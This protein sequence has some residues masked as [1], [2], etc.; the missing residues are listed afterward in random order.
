MSVQG[1]SN[2][3]ASDWKDLQIK[4]IGLPAPLELL[5]G[6]GQDLLYRQRT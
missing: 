6:F 5:V 1:L 3:L 4:Q 2:L